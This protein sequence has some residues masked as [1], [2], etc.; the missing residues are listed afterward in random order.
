[1]KISLFSFSADTRPAEAMRLAL[2]GSLHQAH[3][4]ELA[5]VVAAAELTLDFPGLWLRLR[6]S[7]LNAAWLEGQLCAAAIEDVLSLAWIHV[8]P[9]PWEAGHSE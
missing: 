6:A 8:L 7:G 4:P 9:G 2:M 3:R 1:V 5:D